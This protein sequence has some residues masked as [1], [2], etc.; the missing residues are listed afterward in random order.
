VIRSIPSFPAAIAAVCL[1]A[2]AGAGP[3]A[4]AQWNDAGGGERRLQCIS[5]ANDENFCAIGGNHGPVRLVR[6]FG[7]NA[8]VEGSTWRYDAR[9]VY[10]RNGCRGEFAFG[11]SAGSGGWQDSSVEVRCNSNDGRERFCPAENRGVTLR[12]TESRAPCVQG[13][14]WRSDRR[15][16]Y[17]RNGCRG[18]FVART[19]GGG[20]NDGGW[21]GGGAGYAPIQIKCQSIGG[22][23]GA[24]PVDIDGPVRLVRKESRAA[25]TRGW[26]WGVLER[27]AI[28]VSDGCRAIF[29]VQSGR[30]ASG[31]KPYD[32]EGFAPPGISRQKE[33]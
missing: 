7:P 11:S 26:T 16:I 4:A 15:G 13:E 20:G 18:V 10:V 8:C 1:A 21:R 32:G 27:E 33:E 17:V 19:G 25:C 22:R 31:R 2:L 24:C 30:A 5:G 23:W 3:P 28:W 14:S 29:E 6:S 9:G 12:K